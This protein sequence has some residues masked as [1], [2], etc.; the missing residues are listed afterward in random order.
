MCE[1]RVF[2]QGLVGERNSDNCGNEL[3]TNNGNSV[4]NDSKFE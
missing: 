3:R 1:E 4:V 2:I